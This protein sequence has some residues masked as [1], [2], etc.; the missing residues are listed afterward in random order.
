ML[1]MR[2]RF[3][4]TVAV[5]YSDPYAD[6]TDCL[7]FQKGAV[8]EVSEIVSLSQQFVNINLPSGIVLLDIRKDSFE[9]MKNL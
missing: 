6:D 5:D 7:T 3:N 2:I 8:I 4:K 1:K 9:E